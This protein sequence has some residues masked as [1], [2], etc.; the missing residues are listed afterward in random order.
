MPS[1]GC[2]RGIGLEISCKKHHMAGGEERFRGIGHAAQLL[3]LA[4]RKRQTGFSTN[5]GIPFVEGAPKQPQNDPPRG[6]QRSRH[7]GDPPRPRRPARPFP[8]RNRAANR[9]LARPCLEAGEIAGRM[10]FDAV[11]TTR[12]PKQD[13]CDRSRPTPAPDDSYLHPHYAL[14]IRRRF[15]QSAAC[16]ILRGCR[17]HQALTKG[18]HATPG[19]CALTGLAGRV[20]DEFRA[21]TN[22]IDHCEVCGNRALALR[23]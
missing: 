6:W 10:H 3:D 2:G 7:P 21:A 20:T 19:F 12:Q 22:E 1:C 4:R 18:Q 23:A 15:W 14:S 5:T 13:R 17:A 9:P 8:R 16:R 11:H